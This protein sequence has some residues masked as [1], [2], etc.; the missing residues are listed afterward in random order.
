MIDCS[1]SMAYRDWKGQ[2]IKAAKNAAI[3][4]V[5]KKL[6][7]D[8]NDEIGLVWFSSKAAI[9]VPLLTVGDNYRTIVDGINRLSPTFSTNMV[10]GLEM[11]GS[12]LGLPWGTLYGD[13]RIILLSDGAHTDSGNPVTHANML[14]QLGVIIDCIGIGTKTG[15]DEKTLKAIASVVNGKVRYRWIGDEETLVKH[16]AELSNKLILDR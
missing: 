15:V 7:I 11:A 13:E 2:R 14:K 6:E 3:E 16:F 5:D 12:V 9:E 10:A 4:F 1:G 8:K